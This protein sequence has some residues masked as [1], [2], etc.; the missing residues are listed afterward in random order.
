LRILVL[1]W[2]KMSYSSQTVYRPT[3]PTE[4]NPTHFEL[5]TS[6][7]T[8]PVAKS[9]PHHTRVNGCNRCLYKPENDN[10]LIAVK[11]SS[12]ASSR[13]NREIVHSALSTHKQPA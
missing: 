10:A 12:I 8:T 4:K 7:S 5:A 1:D 6:P 13:I 9:H 3:N 11:N 2:P